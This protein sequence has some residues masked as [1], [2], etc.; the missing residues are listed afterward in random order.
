MYVHKCNIRIFI[1]R[2]KKMFILSAF[3]KIFNLCVCE[4]I[5]V[6]SVCMV[7]CYH[8]VCVRVTALFQTLKGT[9]KMLSYIQLHTHRE[10]IANIRKWLFCHFFKTVA[11]CL[12]LFSPL[13]LFLC[14]FLTSSYSCSFFQN[15]I[16]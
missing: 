14:F 13:P 11:H 2:V 12:S 16:I 1:C 7:M 5:S 15:N 3:A 8:S 4:S 10:H 6:Q 9:H